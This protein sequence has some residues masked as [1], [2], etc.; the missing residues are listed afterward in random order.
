MSRVQFALR[1]ADPEGSTAIY[2][3]LFAAEP[4]KRRPGYASHLG[5]EA[6]TTGEVAA[7]IIR[8]AAEGVRSH[9]ERG[10]R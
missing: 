1:V 8:L 2:S 10:V 3:R 4:A 9:D 5:V 7:T 6:E